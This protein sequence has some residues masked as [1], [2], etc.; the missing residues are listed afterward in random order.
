MSDNV[1]GRVDIS[2][3]SSPFANGE[4]LWP[5]C[6]TGLRAMMVW[7]EDMRRTASVRAWQLRQRQREQHA[8]SAD[9]SLLNAC[10]VRSPGEPWWT[11]VSPAEVANYLRLGVPRSCQPRIDEVRFGTLN[12]CH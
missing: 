9:L 6:P 2:E 8:P 7:S 11:R 3:S 10:S 4:P 12:Y 1:S 5:P